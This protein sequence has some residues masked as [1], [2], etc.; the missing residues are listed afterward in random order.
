MHAA[1][2]YLL[3]A[4]GTAAGTWLIPKLTEALGRGGK[5]AEAAQK[6]L[7]R[8]AERAKQQA[9]GMIAEAEGARRGRRELERKALGLSTADMDALAMLMA[10]I[11]IES[12]QNPKERV[13][14][15]LAEMSGMPDL[16]KRLIMASS[17]NEHP[18]V[19]SLPQLR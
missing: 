2:P 19:S 9:L 14:S 12:E 18:L 7:I 6:R 1:I 17:A 13:S 10:G 16:P 8:K 15:L 4:G 5:S 11:G 3:W